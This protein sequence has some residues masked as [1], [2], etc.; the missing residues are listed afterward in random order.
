MVRATGRVGESERADAC[1]VFRADARA[2]AEARR[3]MLPDPVVARLAETFSALGDTTRVRI[4]HALSERELCVCDLASLLAMTPSA[5]SHQLRLLRH[6]RLV[7][8]RKAGRMVYYS[9]D[10]DHVVDLFRRGLEHV[11]HEDSLSGPA[12]GTE[13]T[14]PRREDAGRS[15]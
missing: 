1:E 8:P 12:G 15:G 14:A 9:L 3:A 6:L 13:V 2:V 10:D 4:L 7:K 11:R 5:V